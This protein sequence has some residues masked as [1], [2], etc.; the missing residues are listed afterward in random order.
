MFQ[1]QRDK[2]MCRENYVARWDDAHR[3]SPAPRHRR[4]LITQWI[5]R[6]QFA[7]CLDAGCAQ[8]YLLE[9]MHQRQIPA[10]GC[11]I[12]DEVIRRNKLQYPYAQFER[13]D[14]VRQVWPGGHRFDLVVCSEVLEH[15]DDWQAALAS[16]TKMSQRYL[17][18]TVPGGKIHP[19]D[20][21]IGH[22]RHFS[23]SELTTALGNQGMDVIRLRRWGWP[24]H[25]LY[26]RAINSIMPGQVY[27]SFGE[28]QY[29]YAKRLFSH[30]IS[31]AFYINDVF[32]WGGQLIILA[33]RRD[34]ER[35]RGSRGAGEHEARI[36]P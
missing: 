31:V 34:Q 27:H 21:H 6:L 25:S 15:V 12:S 7:D 20:R 30:I 26:K 16:L 32:P 4:R 8:P 13:L 10:H 24:M 23:G 19:I 33:Q 28:K 14:L 17:L 3:Y 11:D 1:W 36:F 9:M 22:L 29:G 35:F 18:I 2:T 5:S